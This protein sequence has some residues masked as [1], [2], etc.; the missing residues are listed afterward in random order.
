M[1]V[2]ALRLQAIISTP[3]TVTVIGMTERQNVWDLL[4]C[5]FMKFLV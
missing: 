5:F 3:T 4:V 2:L 1:A